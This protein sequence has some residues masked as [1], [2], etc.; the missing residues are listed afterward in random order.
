MARKRVMSGMRVTGT[1]H[2]GHWLGVL[3]NW[4]RL[5]ESYDCFFAL[6][7][8]HVL[9]TG[10][11]EPSKIRENTREVLLD[12]LAAGVDPEAA[13][14]YVQSAVPEIAELSLLLGMITPM[15]W[16]QRNPTVKEQIADLHLDEDR[17]GYGLLG[18]P[19]LQTADILIMLGDR[20]PVGKDQLPHLELSRDIARRFNSL[21]EPIFPEPEGLLTETPL[22]VGLDGR[23]MSKSY[24]ND[25][26]LG[27]SREEIEKRVMTAITDPARQRRN[28]PGHPEVCT[29][30]A[31][32][33]LF[34]S[35]D[36]E[37]VGQDCR[38]GTLGCV[39]DKRDL[40]R[41][42]DEL[43]APMRERRERLARDPDRLDAIL[44][45]GNAR[46]RRVAAE[47][48]DR[49][50]EAMCLNRFTAPAPT[51]L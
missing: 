4:V 16:L 34:K 29:V 8:W 21:Y 46:A 26:R 13:T 36:V 24:G 33:Q 19:V 38:L 25:I 30:Y 49:V 45:S 1:L 31:Y 18:Y 20:V 42:L 23:K 43:I 51:V 48:M 35:P 6:A 37:R 9:T 40:A 27:S 32:W 10:Y 50:R 7:D 41:Y 11:A 22:V 5:Q 44:S 3:V 39:D 12:W 17:V 47:T 15:T 2:L 28:D 14:L